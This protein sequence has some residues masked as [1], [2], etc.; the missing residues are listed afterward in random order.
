[1]P[2]VFIT[3]DA[4]RDNLAKLINEGIERYGKEFKIDISPNFRFEE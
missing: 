1:M 2:K 3:G 4:T